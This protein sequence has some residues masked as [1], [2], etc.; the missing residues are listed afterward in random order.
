MAKPYPPAPSQG[1]SLQQNCTKFTEMAFDLCQPLPIKETSR[2][3]GKRARI[4]L[5]TGCEMGATVYFCFDRGPQRTGARHAH[6]PSKVQEHQA[7]LAKECA[8]NFPLTL[9]V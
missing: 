8:L 4:H 6:I 2:V 1:E 7:G 5:V 3:I 9:R